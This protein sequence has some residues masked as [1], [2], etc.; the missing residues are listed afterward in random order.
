MSFLSKKIRRPLSKKIFLR[1]ESDA[2]ISPV[3]RKSSHKSVEKASTFASLPGSI[4]LE[5]ALIAP[6]F[7]LALVC[8]LYLVEIMTVQT[9]VKEGLRSAGKEAAEQVYAIPAVFPSQIE[10][11]VVESIGSERL[12]RSILE[13]GA[14]GISCGKS[15]LS[16]FDGIIYLK[17]EY[18]VK[19]PIPL[20][21]IP[22]LK[23]TEEIKVK[24]WTGYQKN[25]LDIGKIEQ[26]VYV[27][28]NGI[29]FHEDPHCTY[30]EPSVKCVPKEAVEDLRNEGGGKYY[31][32][33]YCQ[34]NIASGY[35]YIT[36]TG[37]RYHTSA[38]CSRLKRTVY[39]VPRSEV[40]GKGACSKCVK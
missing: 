13:G 26:M 15:Y 17:A 19:I 31:P 21:A 2:D 36:D 4:T 22:S 35:C 33:R 6:F 37:N 32:C 40:K 29:V 7:F 16:P 34:A 39:A 11:A 9:A 20:F 12:S 27:T 5:T 30:L 10:E 23:Y 38:E 28:A 25:G 14:D 1:K 18:K 24:G 3:R 8:M